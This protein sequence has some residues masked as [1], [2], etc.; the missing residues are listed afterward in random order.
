MARVPFWKTPLSE[1]VTDLDNVLR[2]LDLKDPILI[3]HPLGGAIVQKYLETHP[4]ISAA[5][6][7]ASIPPR[8]TSFPSLRFAWK[9]LS[10]FVRINWLRSMY[11]AVE[12]PLKAQ[13]LFLAPETPME[14]AEEI[15]EDLREESYVGY[16]QTINPFYLHPKRVRIGLPV[17]VL[18]AA[19]DAIF[20]YA[21]VKATALAYH[22]KPVIIGDIGHG[23][24]YDLRWE[25]VAEKITEWLALSVEGEPTAAGLISF[26]PETIL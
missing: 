12:T 26:P 7:L 1:Y 4:Q 6:L 5:V 16:L 11:V 19:N 20:T 2:I 8:G 22:T 10:Q 3:G 17:L 14:I 24:M 18:G 13:R 21:E 9:D 25:T 23:M 15:H